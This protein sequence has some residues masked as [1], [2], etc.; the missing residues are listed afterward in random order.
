MA[1]QKVKSVFA[2]ELPEGLEKLLEDYRRHCRK[3]GLREGSVGLYEK[4]CRWFL[5]NLAE[6]GCEDVS[7]INSSRIVS[8]VPAQTLFLLFVLPFY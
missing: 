7:Q 6:Y 4:E 2:P 3:N 5:Y 8:A 1:K